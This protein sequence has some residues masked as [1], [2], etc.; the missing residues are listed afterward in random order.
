[1]FFF[2]CLMIACLC[3]RLFMCALWSPAGEWMTSWLSFAVSNGESVTF[4][5]VFWVRCGICMYRFLIFAP[6]LT[7]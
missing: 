5:S 3:A 2:L 4:Q 7:L 6:L 1:M